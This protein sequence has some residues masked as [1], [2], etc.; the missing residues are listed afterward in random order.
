MC[1]CLFLTT[2]KVPTHEIN[3]GWK[4]A[5]IG[6]IMGSYSKHCV[7]ILKRMPLPQPLQRTSVKKAEFTGT[8]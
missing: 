1:T 2:T 7:R 3:E 5:P 6:S 8:S 4:R